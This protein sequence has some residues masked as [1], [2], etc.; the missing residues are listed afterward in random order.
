MLSKRYFAL[1]LCVAAIEPLQASSPVDWGTLPSIIDGPGG[2]AW[3]TRHPDGRVIVFGRHDENFRNHRLFMTRLVGDR[4]T[5]PVQLPFTRDVDGSAPHFAPDGRSLLFVSTRS[6]DGVARPQG[7]AEGNVWRVDWDGASWGQPHQLPAPINS[8][9]H[10]IDA[11]EVNGGTIYF[12]S[13]RPG[14][15][16]SRPDLYRAVPTRTGYRVEPLTAFNTGETESTLYVTPDQRLIIFHRAND[17]TGLGKD[18][19]FAA[20]RTRS[21]W[22]PVIHLGGGVNSAEFEYGPEISRDGSTLYFT[23]HRSG[24]AAIMA[25]NLRQAMG[26]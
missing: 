23:T 12:S 4:W 18:D 7:Q 9:S 20:R 13:M 26:R 25:V 17:P 21:G 3:L 6:T 14:G 10:E 15:N 16:G 5:E 1:A 24:Q 8:P 11:V 2:E 22:G 19:L